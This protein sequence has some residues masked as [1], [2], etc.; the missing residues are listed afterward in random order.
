MG[1]EGKV[2]VLRKEVHRL[3]SLDPNAADAI[4]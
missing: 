1:A 4:Y 2:N 3:M